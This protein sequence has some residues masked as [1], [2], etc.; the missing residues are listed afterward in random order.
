MTRD[1]TI[2]IAS[3]NDWDALYPMMSLAFNEDGDEESARSE[4]AVFEPERTLVARRGEEI[5]GCAGIYTRR[6]AVPG[7][8]VP[9]AHVTMVS[10][11]ATARR[12]GVLTRFMQR[13]FD[14]MRAAGEPIAALWASEGRIYQ[15][16]GYGLGARRLSMNIDTREVRLT[17]PT[18][19]EGILRPAS[20]DE[21]P[22]VLADVYGQA[23]PRRPGWS[24]RHE[25]TWEYRLADSRERR[26]GATQLQITLHEGGAGV[27]GYA[28]WR[29][30]SDW[31]GRG[32]RGD[33][34]VMEVVTLTATAYRA[35]WQF[36]LTLDLARSTS[37]WFTAIDEPLPYLVNEP[38]RLGL[39]VG[40]SLWVRIVDLPAALSARQY[41]AP[42]DVVLEVTDDRLPHN[43]GR[44]RLT[45]TSGGGASCVSTMDEP[46]LACDIRAL[47]AAYLGDNVF[48]GLAAA[49]L[50]REVRP[51]ALAPVAAA[52]AWHRAPSS[53]EVF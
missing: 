35:L 21:I 13:Q 50:V 53:M 12:Q 44:W 11:A 49:G 24:E 42:V 32:P 27:D 22:K 39:E 18:A 16:F 41:S 1:I 15:R 30:K 34:R 8:T 20:P 14:D 37:A 46:D 6:M 43:A 51:G 25:R 28:L 47:G 33:V 31:D 52:L 48:G 38:R 7:T 9:T 4:R 2:D 45:A 29:V 19:V 36:L 10:V 3:E 23:Y 40:D 26:N 5:V 17:G